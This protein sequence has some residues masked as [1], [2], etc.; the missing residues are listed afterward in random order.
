MGV[1][2]ICWSRPANPMRSIN[3][4]GRKTVTDRLKGKV[5]VVTGAGGPSIGQGCALAMAREGARV[6][7]CNR[8]KGAAAGTAALMQAE[9][10]T[11]ESF[12]ADLTDPTQNDALMAFAV[13]RFGGIDILVNAAAFVHFAPIERMDYEKHWK[14]TLHGEVDLVFLGCKA[15]WEHMKARGGGSIV[16]FG[17]ANAH[18]ALPIAAL[19]HC[20]SKGAV[21]AMTRQLAAEG[22]RH[23][24]RANTVSPGLV[25]TQETSQ[26]QHIPGFIDDA[27]KSTMLG[28]L[29]TVAEVAHCV[30]FLASDEAAWVT[31][32]DYRV[33]G[34]TTAW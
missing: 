4:L 23:R 10:L 19:A 28:R 18:M 8:R 31:G 26:M 16:N 27:V 2:G 22:A 5:A 21:V 6:V 33:D 3:Q 13:E 12:C 9:G 34:G 24:I 32:A 29:G 7:G 11:Y 25:M 20:A 1:V 14:R 17:S 15:V 30:V